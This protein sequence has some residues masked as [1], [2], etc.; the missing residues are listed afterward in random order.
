MLFA[1]LAGLSS[2]T[3][4]GRERPPTAI[5][6]LLV[7]VLTLVLVIGVS[8]PPRHETRY[9]FFLYPIMLTLALV[10]VEFAVRKLLPHARYAATVTVV[11]ALALF[12]VTEDFKPRHLAT[13]DSPE[14]NFRI[15]LGPAVASHYYPRDN[16]R[17]V[18][19][20]LAGRVG[21]DD[22]VVSGVPHLSQYF[23]GVDYFFLDAADPRYSAY[24]CDG[25]ATERWNNLPLL[26]RTDALAGIVATGARIFVV[27]YADRQ[28]RLLG[29]A[30][31]R[32]WPVRVVELSAPGTRSLL[33]LNP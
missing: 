30:E 5:S 32:G 1:G 29:E 8:G 13:I 9:A 27:V 28:E 17:A 3:F 11:A 16:I 12:A 21:A 26:F 24:A 19:D 15:G 25:G 14:S 4:V 6:V 23:P 33:I 2:R 10:A 7:L 31:A 20:W 22:I 18:A